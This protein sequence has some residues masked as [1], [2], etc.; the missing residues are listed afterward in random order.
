MK[1]VLLISSRTQLKSKLRQV[2]AHLKGLHV[3]AATSDLVEAKEIIAIQP[4]FHFMFFG[5]DMPEEATAKFI[6]EAKRKR[7]S[8]GDKTV[9]ILVFEGGEANQQKVAARMMAGFHGFLCEPFSFDS[10]RE[11]AGL[12]E[13]VSDQKT[14]VRMKAA[15]GILLSDLTDQEPASKVVGAPAD[16]WEKSQRSCHWYNKV[17]NESLTQVMT[18]LRGVPLA[19]CW[20]SIKIIRER[21]QRGKEAMGEHLRVYFKNV[22]PPTKNNS[23]QK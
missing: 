11:L 13:L 21:I 7:S 8:D 4:F 20:T 17:T 2:L 3:A 9:F 12:A 16:L 5:T 23:R 6:S 18:K 15:T 14:V 10:V 19:D 1:Q 22:F